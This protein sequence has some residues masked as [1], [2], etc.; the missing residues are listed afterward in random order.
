MA[1]SGPPTPL[2]RFGVVRSFANS[3]VSSTADSG[4]APSSPVG[5][6]S[7]V[8]KDGDI[9]SFRSLYLEIGEIDVQ[10]DGDWALLICLTRE[11]LGQNS[12]T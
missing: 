7:A 1:K 5:S 11:L 10:T 3:L 6:A 9:L 12:A 8:R 4:P 2:I